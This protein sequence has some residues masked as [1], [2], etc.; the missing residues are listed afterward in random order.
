[1]RY[2]WITY[3]K[4]KFACNRSISDVGIRGLLD[5]YSKVNPYIYHY[6]NNYNI[7]NDGIK[8]MNNMREL[9]FML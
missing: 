6:K 9:I 3:Y 5:P 4:I 2:N 8:D 7:T 1:M